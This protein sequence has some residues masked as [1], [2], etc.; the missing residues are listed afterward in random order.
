[1]R[2]MAILGSASLD[3]LASAGNGVKLTCNYVNSDWGQSNH[4]VTNRNVFNKGRDKNEH[5]YFYWDVP[6][7]A[8]S[9]TK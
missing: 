2:E 4:K 8:V 9:G 5:Q 6:A 7:A 1:M 3:A